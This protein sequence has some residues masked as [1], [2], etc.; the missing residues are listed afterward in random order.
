MLWAVDPHRARAVD[1]AGA[2]QTDLAR[3]RARPPLELHHRRDDRRQMRQRFG[4]D[5]LGNFVDRF[6]LRGFRAPLLE[7]GH[8]FKRMPRFRRHEFLR[9]YPLEHAA[10]RLDHAVARHAG[11]TV[12]NERITHDL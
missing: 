11:T 2:Q 4:D 6:K 12:T 7:R 5:R 9:R 1:V 3:P 8:G 10:D